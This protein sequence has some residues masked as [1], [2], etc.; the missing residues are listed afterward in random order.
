MEKHSLYSNAEI[1]WLQENRANYI[2][3]ALADAFNAHFKTA[4]PYSCLNSLCK[5][6][7]IK[8]GR[9]GR[10]QKGCVPHNTG[11]KGVCYSPQ[12]MFKKGHNPHNTDPVGTKKR[13]TRGYW[14]EKVAEKKW[15]YNHVQAWEKVNGPRPKGHLVIFMDGDKDNIDIGNLQLVSRQEHAEL[16]R[17]QYQSKPY[18]LK[19]TIVALSKLVC[20][21][22]AT[23]RALAR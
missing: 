23:E 5:R 14:K 3:K 11:K 16:I 6:K 13:D 15:V 2:G 9:T 22:R 8:T 10:Y 20:K 19:P 1:A 12:T 4:R 17:K 7:K 21:I 18:E